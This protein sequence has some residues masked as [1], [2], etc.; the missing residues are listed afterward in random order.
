MNEPKDINS[1]NRFGSE[2]LD[3]LI[4][5]LQSTSDPRRR[6]EYVLWLGKKLPLL[7]EEHLIESNKVK[8]CISEVYVKGE[9]IDGKIIWRGF[10]DAFIT[11]GLLALLIKGLNNLT[12]EEILGVNESFLKETKLSNSLTPSRSNGFLNI[13]LKMKSQAKDISLARSPS[14]K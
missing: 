8:G 13:L 2:E 7:Q 12:P 4:Q 6:Y 1:P 9:I 5:K 10:S 3:K 14:I 11:K